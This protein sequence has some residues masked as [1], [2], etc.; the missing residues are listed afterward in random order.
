MKKLLFTP[1]LLLVC[2]LGFND[3]AKASHGA[4]FQL[5]YEHMGGLTYKLYFSFYRECSG[6]SEPSTIFINYTSSCNNGGSLSLNK[7]GGGGNGQQVPVQ[8]VQTSSVCT[9]EW[10]YEGT[11]TL[12]VACQD[13]VFSHS[14]GARPANDNITGQPSYYIEAFLNNQFAPTQSSCQWQNPVAVRDFCVGQPAFFDQSVSE[15][16]GD[17]LHYSF[18]GAKVTNMNTNVPYTAPYTDMNQIPVIPTG[19]V[20]IN[21]QTQTFEFTPAQ[22]F[23]GSFCFIV[24]EWNWDTT[25]FNPGQP[26]EYTVVTPVKV[27][28]VMRDLRVI[29]ENGCNVI[30]PQLV[31]MPIDSIIDPNTGTYKNVI[32]YNCGDTAVY[33]ATTGTSVACGSVEPTGSDFFLIDPQT[34]LPYSGNYIN[35]A[36]P[37]CSGGAAD[38]IRLGLAYPLNSGYYYIIVKDGNDLNT[39]VTNC[40]SEMT[41]FEDTLL[42]YVSPQFGLDLPDN[43]T[44][45]VPSGGFPM[46]NA[47]PAD[48]MITWTDSATGNVIDTNSI[49][50]FDTSG[51]YYFAGQYSGCAGAYAYDTVHVNISYDPDIDLPDSAFMCNNSPITLDPGGTNGPYTYQWTF[52]SIN[53]STNPTLSTVTGPGTYSVTA[54]ANPGGCTTTET[55]YV[56]SLSELNII[57]NSDTTVCETF[58][59][60]TLTFNDNVQPPIETIVWSSAQNANLGSGLS[61]DVSAAGY[62]WVT[63]T[64]SNGCSGN[65]S[66]YFTVVPVTIAPTVYCSIDGGQLT[67]TWDALPGVTSY[68][69]S[70]DAGFTWIPANG[71]LSHSTELGQANIFV[72]GYSSTGVCDYS[73]VGVSDACQREITMPNVITPNGDGENDFLVIEYLDL[74]PGSRLLIYDRWGT[75]VL[76]ATD[77]QN[78]WD[79]ADQS[80]GT[81][82]YILHIESP[83]KAVLKGNITLLR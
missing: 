44:A 41:P 73:M 61:Q 66:I 11:V 16:N 50:T 24:E 80:E 79:G 36:N 4:G 55:V 65:D 57:V 42:L 69:V 58:G 46:I 76:D 9:N 8:C 43:L 59:D 21:S 22:Q 15:V 83:D 17:S 75:K 2:L 52:N 39:L 12:P 62:Y 67:F 53:I 51:T 31:G 48:I 32:N 56:G 5:T 77:Y 35:S 47:A 45:C 71:T 27:G 33:V 37:Y 38:S 28:H 82:F 64:D 81:F 49:I 6:I 70:L 78:D 68:E 13:W 63:V 1:L 40:G 23:S 72:R 14:S 34:G 25:V 54:T 7:V 3:S 20:N 60:F 10:R 29:F 19:V 18:I 26:N 30:E 74:Y